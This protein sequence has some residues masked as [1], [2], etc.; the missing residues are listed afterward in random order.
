MFIFIIL[1]MILDIRV[2]TKKGVDYKIYTIKIPLYLK[3]LDFYD[4][5]FNY[6]WLVSQIVSKHD[7][8][9]AKSLKIMDWTY[10]NISRQPAGLKAIDDHVWYI[11]VR[12]YG[13]RDQFS[14]VF[15]TLC[16]YAG[17][18]AFFDRI[19]DKKN[20]SCTQLAFVEINDKWSVF[21]PYTATYFLNNRGQMASVEDIAQKNWRPKNTAGD[22]KEAAY[23]Y[24]AL[25]DN[26]ESIDPE[27]SYQWARSN[28]Q[29]PLRRFFYGLIKR[30]F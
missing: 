27:E 4:R 17:L 14:D 6:K 8:S 1:F 2:S 19:A 12:G 13:T 11:I 22:G 29:S 5:N 9:Q 28:I 25:L 26:I 15:A 30:K 3:V 7:S 23:E 24:A 20:T 21:D 16:N 10:K 18:R